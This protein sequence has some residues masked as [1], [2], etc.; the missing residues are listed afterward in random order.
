[1]KSFE[2]RMTV[3]HKNFDL[4]GKPAPVVRMPYYCSGCPHN[5]STV[6]PEGSRALAGIGCHYMAM[7]MDRRTVMFTQMGGEGVPWIGQAPFTSEK[8]VA[9]APISTPACSPS[10]RRSQRISTSLTKFFTT[11]PSP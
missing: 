1:V 10:A 2:D 11:T 6:V 4:K 7:W 5:T 9:M 8:H 3:I